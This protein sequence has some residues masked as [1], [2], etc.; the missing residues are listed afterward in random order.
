MNID[1]DTSSD[2]ALRFPE[3]KL[4]EIWKAIATSE[5]IQGIG[6]KIGQTI[7]P[8]AK[9]LLASW[10]S[11]T[12]TLREALT[13][14]NKNISLMNPSESWEMKE[15]NGVCTLTFK[16]RKD[17][18]YPHIAIERSMAAMICWGR[19]LS[20]Q[21]FPII[22]AH[23]SFP[24]PKY[25]D[26]FAPIFGQ[27]LKFNATKDTLSFDKKLLGL[28]VISSNHFLKA[29][30]EAKAKTTLEEIDK[31]TP[32]RTKVKT[33]IKES[34]TTGNQ[35]TINQV[36]GCLSMSRQTLY[37][38]LKKDDTDFQTL[39]DLVRKER[40]LYLLKTGT[41]NINTISLNLGYKET[42]SFY[43]AFK[44]WFSLPPKAYLLSMRNSD[45]Q[46]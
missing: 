46:E 37:R 41:E 25:K 40:A 13:I 7:N 39:Y 45:N 31:T 21:Q 18:H 3:S 19:A 8:E 34:L 28:P 1:I 11:Q 26:L 43:K 38:Q 16:L 15:D 2:P 22:E 44:R 12:N 27:H 6:L 30:I 36:S 42:S 24:A 17:K 29:I 32:I 4:I 23:F 10:I 20:G 35:I 5:K 33:I 14:F 9:G